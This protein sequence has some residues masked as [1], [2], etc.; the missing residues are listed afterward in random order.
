MNAKTSNGDTKV[1]KFICRMCHGVC[2]V[3][4]DLNNGRVV[5]ITGDPDSPLSE[6]YVCSNAS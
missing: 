1:V 5:K 4:V 2:G 6:G 3:R